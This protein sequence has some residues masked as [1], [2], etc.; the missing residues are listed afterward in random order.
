RIFCKA[1]D[2][3]LNEP[4]GISI[5]GTRHPLSLAAPAAADHPA[6]LPHSATTI[7]ARGLGNPEKLFTSSRCWLWTS[8]QG[9]S[10]D[11]CAQR[12]AH[13]Y[14]GY[15][16]HCVSIAANQQIL[17]SDV[18]KKNVESSSEWSTNNSCPA[19]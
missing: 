16:V 1:C 15:S 12:G 6:P 10:I 7:S 8:A 14:R 9:D 3:T 2:A 19:R 13:P 4:D 17:L 11:Q 5:P 18:I